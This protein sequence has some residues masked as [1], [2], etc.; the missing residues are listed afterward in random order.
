MVNKGRDLQN[1]TISGPNPVKIHTTGN[2]ISI[3]TKYRP[4]YLNLSK[5]VY[6]KVVS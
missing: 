4:L 3:Q 1:Q 2:Q 5:R 6:R